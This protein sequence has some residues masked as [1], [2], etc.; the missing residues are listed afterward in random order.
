MKVDSYTKGIY[1]LFQDYE[2][3][4]K[5]TLGNLKEQGDYK[6]DMRH[7]E[8]K[9]DQLKTKD[10]ENLVKKLQADLEILKDENTK[11]LA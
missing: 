11:M 3:T 6:I 4:Y 5:K 9:V 8:R 1:K 10:Y 7:H 2:A